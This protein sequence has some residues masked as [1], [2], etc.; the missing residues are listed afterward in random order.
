M[1]LALLTLNLPLTP[2][3]FSTSKTFGRNMVKSIWLREAS[4]LDYV[5]SRN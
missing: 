3:E 1:D 2:E 4:V 5:D